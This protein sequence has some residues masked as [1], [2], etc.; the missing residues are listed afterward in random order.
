MLDGGGVV[1]TLDLLIGDVTSL[2]RISCFIILGS[3]GRPSALLA[4]EL[5]LRDHDIVRVA[6]Y[7][8]ISMPLLSTNLKSA[9]PFLAGWH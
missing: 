3:S 2:L 9:D 5:G 4:S 8:V 6:S 7:T 1:A